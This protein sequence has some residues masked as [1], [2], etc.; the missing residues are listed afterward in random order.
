MVP[1]GTVAGVLS[2][3]RDP[4]APGVSSLLLLLDLEL[5]RLDLKLDMAWIWMAEERKLLFKQKIPNPRYAPMDEWLRGDLVASGTWGRCRTP[6]KFLGFPAFMGNRYAALPGVM[7]NSA[8]LVGKNMNKNKKKQ[9]RRERNGRNA[10]PNKG[11]EERRQKDA[12]EQA[13][14]GR[15]GSKSGDEAFGSRQDFN[16]E[17][18]EGTLT[19]EQANPYQA[20][21]KKVDDFVLENSSG[22]TTD[23]SESSGSLNVTQFSQHADG[24]NEDIAETNKSSESEANVVKE[25]N[26]R[27]THK[28]LHSPILGTGN[29]M[30][31][32]DEMKPATSTP[33]VPRVALFQQE[34]ADPHQSTPDG[35][36]KKG[37]SIDSTTS[38]LNHNQP[39]KL[40]GGTNTPP[41]GA[42]KSQVEILF[43][44]APSPSSGAVKEQG[45]LPPPPVQNEM[46]LMM[47]EIR[48]F[49]AMFV[50]LEGRIDAMED[51]LRSITNA[52]L[53]AVKGGRPYDYGR[54]EGKLEAV[55]VQLKMMAALQIPPQILAAKAA[56]ATAA[57]TAD[58]NGAKP[59]RPPESAK[60]T[61]EAPEDQRPMHGELHDPQGPNLEA[62]PGGGWTT[63]GRRRGAA[64][65]TQNQPQQ[66][67]KAQKRIRERPDRIVVA[68]SQQRTFAETLRLIKSQVPEDDGVDQVHKMHKTENGDLVVEMRKG[69]TKTR[70]LMGSI[71]N[72]VGNET[73]TRVH[74]NSLEALEIKGLEEDATDADIASAINKA[75]EGAAAEPSCVKWIRPFGARARG[76]L[77]L[78]SA[79]TARS[80][81]AQ[82][83]LRVGWSRCRVRRRDVPPVARCFKCQ[84]FGH[85]ARMCSGPDR[86]DNCHMC[87]GAGHK[88]N[89]CSAAPRCFVCADLA[90]EEGKAAVDINHVAGRNGCVVYAQLRAAVAANGMGRPPAR[91]K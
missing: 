18:E 55:E 69:A 22:E 24:G 51:T 91:P 47:S 2:L 41:S 21:H 11:E 89:T 63:Q 3:Q 72:V 60:R 70:Q 4:K 86:R 74:E 76:A 85:E 49:K 38:P 81:I 28:L 33:N 16:V 39:K 37:D 83:W 26:F 44:L 19:S 84:G 40:K 15:D 53:T 12:E 78:I 57:T 64:R 20:A 68:K 71:A 1:G 5:E 58:Y 14:L 66:E 62:Q 65:T 27:S 59:K 43:P 34:T 9:T 77:I 32:I 56:A 31:R 73:A 90:P 42:N 88:A 30:P 75:I 29:P 7:N 79:K 52:S 80:L 50:R 17:H 46:E 25:G 36:R 13:V 10:T 8:L 67:Q 45:G 35:K 82:G 61:R 48:S 6:R 87:G 23:S 54:L